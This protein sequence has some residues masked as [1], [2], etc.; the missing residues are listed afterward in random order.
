VPTYR[1]IEVDPGLSQPLPA[2]KTVKPIGDF[3]GDDMR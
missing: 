3:P 2:Q 1:V